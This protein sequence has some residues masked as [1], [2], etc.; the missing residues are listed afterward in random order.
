MSLMSDTQGT[1]E[2]V[3]SLVNLLHA[4]GGALDREGVKVWLDPFN[5]DAK[6]TA[7][8]NTIGAAASLDLILPDRS[9]GTIRLLVDGLPDTQAG[10]ADWVHDKLIDTPP[11]HGNS[12]VLETYA[13]FVASSAREKGTLWIQAMSTEP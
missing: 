10:F 3:W 6:G 9:T 1:P 4:H 8:L 2:R 5:T 12:V 13:W 11:D 7:V